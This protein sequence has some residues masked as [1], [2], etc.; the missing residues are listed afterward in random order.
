MYQV[1]PPIPL[2][3]GGEERVARLFA[4]ATE[5]FGDDDSQ[6]AWR[7]RTDPALGRDDRGDAWTPARLAAE[8]EDGLERLL[9]VLDE[10]SKTVTPIWKVPIRGRKTRRR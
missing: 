1:A 4:R 6:P 8:S 10:L 7:Y 9:A 5:V 2:P 3:P